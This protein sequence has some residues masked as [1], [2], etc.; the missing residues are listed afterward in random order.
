MPH[1][2]Q[3]RKLDLVFRCALFAAYAAV[4]LALVLRHEPKA[5]ELQAWLIARDCTI[6]EIFHAMRWEGHFVPWYLM[7]HAFA[8]N[9]CPVLCMNLLS[10]AFMAAA[11]AFFLFRAP[12]TFPMKLLVL[13]SSAML[14][15]YPVVARCY[16]LIPILLFALA[17]AWPARLK[18]PLLFGFLIACLTNTHAYFEG[19]CG[20]VFVLWAFDAWKL[21]AELPRRELRRIAAG[22]CIAA[23]GALFGFLQVAPGM[24]DARSVGNQRFWPMKMSFY[25]RLATSFV[26]F[27]GSSK[28]VANVKIPVLEYLWAALLLL[29]IVWIVRRWRSGLLYLAFATFFFGAFWFVLP[30]QERPSAFASGFQL[31]L[32]FIFLPFF[33]VAM[34]SLFRASR[35][36]GAVCLAS[37]LWMILFA[38]FLFYF[39]PQRALLV[40]LTFLFCHWVL[41]E[42]PEERNDAAPGAF[43]RFLD[44]PKPLYLKHLAE[45]LAIYICFSI[46]ASVSLVMMDFRHPFSGAKDMGEYLTKNLPPGSTVVIPFYGITDAV[47]SAYAPGLKFYCVEAGK[48]ITFCPLD[49]SQK[50][51]NQKH[52]LIMPN[53]MQDVQDGQLVCLD[54]NGFMFSPQWAPVVDAPGPHYFVCDMWFLG[55][56]PVGSMKLQSKDRKHLYTEVYR[57]PFIPFTDCAGEQYWLFTDE[58][59]P[60]Q[61][62]KN[63]PPG[64]N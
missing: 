31:V 15:W 44:G 55:G 34:L 57:S 58:A 60:V 8:A 40:F 30:Q 23:A 7:L 37:F 59:A 49:W 1:E 42:N 5:D 61:E 36:M 45:A 27:A 3:N 28:E 20:I 46:P 35:R 64:T 9:G 14:F 25:E 26:D 2:N 50:K 62:D 12:F 47:I 53:W 43:F 51:L 24:L 63:N 22:L 11:G 52:A 39:L 19:F 33:A 13:C 56:L 17:A 38:M 54:S 32:N 6:P 10:W 41:L 4:T 18:R 29:L 21:R 48:N 16:A